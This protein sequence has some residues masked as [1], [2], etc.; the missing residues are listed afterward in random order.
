MSRKRACSRSSIQNP[1]S[2]IQ[3]FRCWAVSAFCILHSAFCAAGPSLE[4]AIAAAQ[5]RTVKLYGAQFG[6]QQGYGSGVVVSNDGF[7]VTALASLLESPSLR[8]VLHDGR[9][10]P[11]TIVARDTQRQ[12]A[13]LKI[14]A[15]ELSHF[16]MGSSE[17]LMPGDWVIAAA[18]PFKVAEGPEAVSV[19]V[20][21]LSG[22]AELAARRKAQDFPYSGQVLLTD[23]VIATPG[24][25]GGALVDV[26]G[27]LVGVIGK[28]VESTRT[29]T[30]AN[31]AM[32]VEQVA[33][34]VRRAQAG[35]STDGPQAA[36]ASQPS[37]TRMLQLGI[38]LLDYGSR[39][40]PPY[41]ERVRP[42][43]PAAL[44]AVRSGDL[45]L[46]IAGNEVQT[47][48]DAR[49]A[50]DRTEEAAT[51]VLVVKRGEEVKNV[52]IRAENAR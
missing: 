44:A 23:I 35:E 7:I 18:N 34:F 22:R 26:D 6:K 21:V 16:E 39:T 13:L 47:C 33:E 29:N 12:L 49:T 10:Y 14:D 32:P 37:G 50:L 20:G 4:P 41:V 5:E 8:A 30:L 46:S 19:A 9:R 28:M 15:A 51:I 27:R 38:R 40:Q 31:Y 24:S 11:A 48:A 25:A 43:S 17:H 52:E 2:K 45:I 36:A 42:D 3:N 1:K